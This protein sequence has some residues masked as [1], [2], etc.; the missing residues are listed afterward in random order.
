MVE[1]KGVTI[2]I[3]PKAVLFLLGTE[4]D[5]EVDR[6]RRASC[7]AI[8]TRPTPAA[9]ANWW[10]SSR[11]ASEKPLRRGPLISIRLVTDS[12]RALKPVGRPHD[13]FAAPREATLVPPIPS[14]A[15]AGLQA[16][17]ARLLSLDMSYSLPTPLSPPPPP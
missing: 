13:L 16:V 11:A 10:S 2:L 5:Y 8:P 12:L 6:M 9:A 4:I 14:L 7:S 17:P 15:A 3:E 1:D